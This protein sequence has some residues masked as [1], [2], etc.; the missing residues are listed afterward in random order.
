MVPVL[1]LGLWHTLLYSTTIPALLTLGKSHYQAVGNALYCV[2]V[3]TAIP[4]AFHFYGM[5]GAV[6]AVAAGD[7]PFYLVMVMAAS[8]E[9]VSTWRQDLQATGVF[10]IFLAAG[11]ALRMAIVHH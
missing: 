9:K 11:M 6:V 10:A 1:A 5:F 4:V 3:L 8:K 2:A 7:F